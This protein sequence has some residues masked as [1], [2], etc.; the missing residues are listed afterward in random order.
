M[1]GGLVLEERGGAEVVGACACWEPSQV[2]QAVASLY[3]A[4]IPF[5]LSAAA[6]PGQRLYFLGIKS[7][8]SAALCLC[9]AARSVRRLRPDHSVARPTPN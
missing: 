2:C 3:M 8:T 7:S 6:Q 1:E 9:T 4:C 5:P